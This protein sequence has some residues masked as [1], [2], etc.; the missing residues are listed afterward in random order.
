MKF[1]T[2]NKLNILIMNIVLGIDDLDPKSQIR[3]NLVPILKFAPI[4]M[5]FD[6]HNKSNMF[7]INIGLDS[8]QSARVIIGSE[9]GTIIRTIKVPIVV[10]CSELLQV[11]KCDS[12]LEHD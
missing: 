10:P 8:L 11:V 3:A 2:Q 5:K 7:V 9:H 6:T 4:F 1:G 12:H